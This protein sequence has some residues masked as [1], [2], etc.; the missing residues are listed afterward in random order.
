MCG[1]R[2]FT[3]LESIDVRNVQNHFSLLFSTLILCFLRLSKNTETETH[4][5]NC[6]PIHLTQIKK[7][8]LK[9]PICLQ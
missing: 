1:L 9:L 3:H 2:Q 5:R 8:K 4:G 7:Q 6:V